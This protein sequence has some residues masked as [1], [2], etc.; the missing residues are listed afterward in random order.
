MEYFLHN[1][2]SFDTDIQEFANELTQEESL[3]KAL[4]EICFESKL[5]YQLQKHR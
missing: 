1:L 2:K 5:V 3:Q 4:T